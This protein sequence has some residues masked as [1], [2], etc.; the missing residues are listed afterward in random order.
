MCDERGAGWAV[1]VPHVQISELE[2]AVVSTAA[3][4]DW[5]QQLRSWVDAGWKTCG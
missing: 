1:L 4:T 5:R 3:K 2:S